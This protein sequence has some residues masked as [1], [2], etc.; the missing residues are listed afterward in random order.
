MGDLPAN[1]ANF[2]NDAERPYRQFLGPDLENLIRE[3][4]D[5]PHITVR[6]AKRY[7][8]ANGTYSAVTQE[9]HGE[10]GWPG[11]HP[12]LPISWDWHHSDQY[13]TDQFSAEQ[14]E[15]F[16][17]IPYFYLFGEGSRKT[18]YSGTLSAEYIMYF[19]CL[20]TRD[21]GKLRGHWSIRKLTGYGSDIE[22]DIYRTDY[23]E[24]DDA[25]VEQ[26]DGICIFPNDPRRFKWRTYVLRDEMPGRSMLLV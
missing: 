8:G 9:L 10:W 19:Q 7:A 24:Q 1:F 14:L 17:D 2:A 16:R 21:T 25:V 5:F 11:R 20:R 26:K 18:N 6:G 3:Y 22:G 12:S 13:H 15:A 4:A 23:I